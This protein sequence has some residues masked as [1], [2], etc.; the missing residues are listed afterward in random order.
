MAFDQSARE[1][2]LSYCKAAIVYNQPLVLS[3]GFS[4]RYRLFYQ[5][6]HQQ[7]DP[8]EEAYGHIGQRE[9]LRD[10]VF[11]SFHFLNLRYVGPNLLRDYLFPYR[12]FSF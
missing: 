4:W 9:D 1:D 11:I 3:H 6:R 2:S 8:A 12:R 10:K 5:L 7:E